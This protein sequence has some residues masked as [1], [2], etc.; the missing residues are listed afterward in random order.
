MN[1]F[2]PYPDNIDKSIRSL[3]DRRLT[4][5]ILECQT[6]IDVANGQKG[7][8][9]HPIVKHYSS[10]VKQLK[11]VRYYA[12][13]CCKEFE[14]RFGKKHAYAPR[15]PKVSYFFGLAEYVPLYLEG[16]KPNQL[17]ITDQHMVGRMFREKLSMKWVLDKYEPKWTNRK[18]PEFYVEPNE[19]LSTEELI[20][21]IRYIYEKEDA[22]STYKYFIGGLNHD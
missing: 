17:I 16:S 19:V 11:F 13:R 3:D 18:K 2:L 10:S 8:S 4:K 20:K 1:I 22:K 6:I 12:H 9:N 14:Y 5:Q 7:Y 21:C 15:F